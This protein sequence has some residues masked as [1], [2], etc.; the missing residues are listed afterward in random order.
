M[1]FEFRV[2][3]FESARPGGGGRGES[4]GTRTRNPKLETE[5]RPCSPSSTRSPWSASTP[6][7][8]EVEVDV[9]P[10][11]CP[12]RSWSA[13]PRRPSGRASTASSG[14]WPTS[15]TTATAGRTVINLA[16]ADLHEGR[17]R[18]RPADRAGPARR[19]RPAAAR[20]AGGLRHGRRAG[21]RRQRAAGQGRA[22]DGHGRRPSAASPSCSSPPPTPARPPSSRSVARLRR[23][24]PGR[25][26]RHPLRPARRRAGRVATS[27]SCSPQLNTLRRGLRRRP[28][29][30]VRQAGPRGRRR[31]RPQRPDDR[32]PGHRQ[33]DA[34]PAA[35][36]DPAAADA[37]REP[38]DD[39]HLHAPWA[40]CRPASR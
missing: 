18:L 16:P 20:A 38:G 28:R 3:S 8:V 33:D 2:P 40:G 4:L 5:S 22:V 25:G 39:A 21:P 10:P 23:R 17:R 7:P 29:P 31:R 15:A 11:A 9:S 30:G 32:L 26:G 36:D 13:C 24:Q 14:P 35:A 1:S 6:C 12:R 34:G 19:H 27:T 37:G